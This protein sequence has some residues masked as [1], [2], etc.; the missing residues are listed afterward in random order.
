MSFP[1]LHEATEEGLLAMGGDLS[2]ERLRLAYRSGIFPWYEDD[3]PILWWS[4]DPRCVLYPKDFKYSRSLRRSLRKAQFSYTFDRAFEQVIDQ[5][6]A[7]RGDNSGTWITSDMRTAYIKLHELGVAHSVEAWQ[8]THLAGGLYGLAMGRVFFGESMFSAVTDA[9]KAAL[10]HL[11]EHLSKQ[12]FALIDC[13]VSSA[14]L[15]SLGAQEI[16]RDVFM[17][18]IAIALQSEVAEIKWC[19]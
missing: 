14:H 1:P 7:P 13:Q 10:G 5:C 15:L 16:S 9:S 4:P 12:M 3:Q 17:Q 19:R 11:C 6:A 8:G 18:Q 2:P